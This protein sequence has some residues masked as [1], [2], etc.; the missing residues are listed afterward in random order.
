V[1]NSLNHK[2]VNESASDDS[3]MLILEEPQLSLLDDYLSKKYKDS[4]AKLNF[5]SLEYFRNQIIKEFN[6]VKYV[7]KC[8]NKKEHFEKIIKYYDSRI[9]EHLIPKKRAQNTFEFIDLFCGAGGLSCGLEQTGF[10]PSL[11]LDKDKPSLQTYHFNR[12]FLNSNQIINDD[13]REVIKDF[14]FEN[15]PLIVGGP[16][17]QGFS[18]ANKQKKENDDRNELYK[19]YLHTVDSSNP[20]IFLLENVEGILKFYEQIQN[21]FIDI[22][23]TLYPYKLNT[24]DFGFPQNRKRVFILGINNKHLKIHNELHKIFNDT[25]NSDMNKVN[26]S[27]W[28]AISDLPKINA[29]TKRNSSDL[30]SNNWGYTFGEFKKHNSEYSNFINVNKDL[31]SPLLNHKAKFNNERDIEIYSLLK[32]GEGS[33]SKSIEEINPYLNRGDIFKDKFY[34]LKPDEPSKTI[35]AHMYYD[36]HMYIH[37]FLSRGLTPREAARVQGFPDDYLFLGSPNE[38]YRQIGNAVSPLLARVIGKAL[39]KVLNRIYEF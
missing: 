4:D 23:Y 34:K 20:D 26:F 32:P 18:N 9:V 8:L 13:I 36:C 1:K 11:A 28:D 25:I 16:P 22:N 3:R 14:E 10:I 5:D 38:W 30:E 12:P 7:D 29:K 17:C 2:S 27:L 33:N 39:N 24:K 15:T 37:P 31:F 35:T 19:F 21:D 6:K